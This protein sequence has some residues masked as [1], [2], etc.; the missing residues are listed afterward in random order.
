MTKAIYSSAVVNTKI[1]KN[2]PFYLSFNVMLS[3]L[4]AMQVYWF[5][6][7]MKVVKKI[8]VG[9]GMVDTRETD[10]ELKAWRS[11]MEKER[12]DKTQLENQK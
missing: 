6:M 2:G 11:A 3:A 7:I 12:L 1:Y 4:Y 9:E 10:E 8:I 5:Y